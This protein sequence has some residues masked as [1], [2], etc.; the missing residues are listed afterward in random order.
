MSADEGPD[1]C[2]ISDSHTNPDL[3]PMHTD[4][5]V[6]FFGFPELYACI[7]L[8]QSTCTTHFQRQSPNIEVALQT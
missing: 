5:S 8:H 4:I 1:K 6:S 3:E 2:E 7:H